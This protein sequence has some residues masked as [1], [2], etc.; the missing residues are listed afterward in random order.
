MKHPSNSPPCH[1]PLL[2]GGGGA[3]QCSKN[4]P[5]QGTQARHLCPGSYVTASIEFERAQVTRRC[6]SRRSPVAVAR[7]PIIEKAALPGFHM[8]SHSTHSRDDC[9]ACGISLVIVQDGV[10]MV[11]G[12]EYIERS[13]PERLLHLLNSSDLQPLASVGKC[14]E[15]RYNVR[16][17]V[18]FCL[19]L[20]VCAGNLR[21]ARWLHQCAERASIANSR[22]TWDEYSS[23]SNVS[24]DSLPS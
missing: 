4:C 2:L 7:C 16:R 9:K 6:N 19:Q 3:K 11:G 13:Q 18:Y 22:T 14:A 10:R 8:P 24:M 15:C 1:P 17:A 20:E 5:S 23:T 21:R 12:K